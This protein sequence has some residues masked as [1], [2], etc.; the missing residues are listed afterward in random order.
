MFPKLQN[1]SKKVK[2]E[3]YSLFDALYVGAIGA[4]AFG[5]QKYNPALW[6]MQIELV[7]SFIIYIACL[8]QLKP[9]LKHFFY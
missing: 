3:N 5:I 4:F 6:T 9:N 2:L 7:S 8:L 1:G